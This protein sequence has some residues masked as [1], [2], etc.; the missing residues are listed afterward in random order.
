MM[1]FDSPKVVRLLKHYAETTDYSVPD[2]VFLARSNFFSNERQCLETL[3]AE[4]PEPKQTDWINRLTET[5]H[6]KYIGAW[7]EIHLWAWLRSFGSAYVEPTYGEDKPDFIL[8]TGSEQIAIEGKAILVDAAERKMQQW[9][10]QVTYA[11]HGIQRPY[12]IEIDRLELTAAVPDLADFVDCV[13]TWL[14][15]QP[16]EPFY[17]HPADSVHIVLTCLAR[18]QKYEHIVT[19]GPT[20]TRA[21][22][23]KSLHRPLRKK[24]G[25]HSDVRAAGLPYVVAIFIEPW[26]LSAEDIAEAWFGQGQIIYDVEHNAV[27]AH[28]HDGTGISYFG[29]QIQ[30][31]SVSGSLV[32]R[33][34]EPANSSCNPFRCWFIQN[35][36]ARTPVRSDMFPV[37]SSYVVE[38]RSPTAYQMRWR[39]GKGS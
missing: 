2:I 39:Q 9:Q 34:S 22:N 24:P 6:D 17:Y 14:D 25:Q 11:I 38:G 7:F 19:I 10:S 3:I 18:D 27:T 30:H 12:M 5:S 33:A 26:H 31:T 4:A 36:F 23:P 29:S 15:N 16:T 1:I 28:Q 35:P 20:T 37:E 13:A 8:D 21:S 32:F